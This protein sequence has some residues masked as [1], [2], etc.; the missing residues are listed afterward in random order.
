MA[1]KGLSVFDSGKTRACF[2]TIPITAVDQSYL[3][4]RTQTCKSV[5]DA[6]A[7]SNP[8]II[9]GAI[10][11]CVSENGYEHLHMAVEAD[12]N[13]TRLY[14][15]RHL[16]NIGIDAAN[17]EFMAGPKAH[18][19]AYIRKE[20][21]FKESGEK[22][23]NTYGTGVFVGIPKVKNFEEAVDAFRQGYRPGELIAANPNLEH[24]YRGVYRRF[25]AFRM[26]ELERYV[27]RRMVWHI[28]LPGPGENEVLD[29]LGENN[30]FFVPSCRFGWLDAYEGEGILCFSGYADD[31]KLSVGELKAINNN[32]IIPMN[33]RNIFRMSLWKEVHIISQHTPQELY[34]ERKDRANVMYMIDDVVFHYTYR[35]NNGHIFTKDYTVDEATTFEEVEREAFSANKAIRRN[36]LNGQIMQFDWNSYMYVYIGK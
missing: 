7:T 29:S 19:V 6:Y 30:T 33:T 15:A 35:A 3:C 17:V 9:A 26:G 18:A 23:I 2:M 24:R 32:R 31:N 4:D 10:S 34:R 5:W 16:S 14:F 27:E 1:K 8:H 13:Y 20:G 36:C 22:V 11:L 25:D 12:N 28:V 21:D